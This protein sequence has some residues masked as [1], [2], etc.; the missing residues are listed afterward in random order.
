[1]KIIETFPGYCDPTVYGVVVAF[2]FEK[3]GYS[4]YVDFTKDEPDG[5]IHHFTYEYDDMQ[6]KDEQELAHLTS[7]CGDEVREA[8]APMYRGALHYRDGNN[9]QVN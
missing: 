4:A 2:E 9:G 3:V 8:A 6:V 7:L 1:M 5:K